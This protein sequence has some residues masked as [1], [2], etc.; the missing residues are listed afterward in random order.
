MYAYEGIPSALRPEDVTK[1]L[2]IT[3]QD[4]T[5]AG[6]RDYAILQLLATYGLLELLGGCLGVSE[7]FSHCRWFYT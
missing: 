5:S 1:A 7:A 3:R 6:I 4:T 2:A